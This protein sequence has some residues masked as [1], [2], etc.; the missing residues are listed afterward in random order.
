M[1]YSVSTI[2]IL[3]NSTVHAASS[4]NIKDESYNDVN[5]P[6]DVLDDDI[7]MNNIYDVE[8]YALAH[9]ACMDHDIDYSDGSVV[10][11][12]KEWCS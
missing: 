3:K 11:S 9:D 2:H 10:E 5:A 12:K 4:V 7:D 8:E 6:Y 1:M